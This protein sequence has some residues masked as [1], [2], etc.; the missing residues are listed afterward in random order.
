MAELVPGPSRPRAVVSSVYTF[1]EAVGRS[2]RASDTHWF[3]VPAVRHL[4][5]DLI[6]SLIGIRATL[7]TYD[8][9][10]QVRAE[11]LDPETIIAHGELDA[12]LIREDENSFYLPSGARIFS[13]R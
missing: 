13:D 8:G 6:R 11:V 12:S 7:T 4:A 5:A 9:R 2:N 3:L 1:V 10:E